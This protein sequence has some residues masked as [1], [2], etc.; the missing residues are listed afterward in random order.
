MYVIINTTKGNN[1]LN[2][3]TV[4]HLQG[5]WIYPLCK[6][7]NGGTEGESDGKHRV[8]VQACQRACKTVLTEWEFKSLVHLQVE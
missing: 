3:L 5:L 7:K 6:C 2:S 8:T 1:K 4:G